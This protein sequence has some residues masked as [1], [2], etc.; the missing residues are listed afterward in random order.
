MNWKSGAMNQGHLSEYFDGA[1]VKILSPVDAEPKSSNQHEIGTTVPMRKFLGTDKSEFDVTYIWLNDEQETITDHGFAT[2]YNCR[3]GKPRPPEYRLYYT[4][5]AVTDIMSAGDTLFLAIRPDETILFIVVPS[6]STIQSQLL[7]LFGLDDEPQKKFKFAEFS[8]DDSKVDFISRFILDEIGIEFEDPDANSLDT[9]I[10]RFGLEFPKTAELSELARLTLPEVNALDDPDFALTAWLD[11]EEALFRRLEKKVVAERIQEGFVNED[12]V[13]VDGFIKYSLSVQ[14]RRKSRMGHSFENQ[15]KAVFDAFKLRYD[16]Q[17]I[18]EKGKK[19]DFIF[20]GKDEYF[21]PEFNTSR[22][23]MLAAKSTCKDRWPQILPEA[24]RIE[25]KHL[26]TLEPAI[27]LPQTSLMQE[28][29]VQ[30]IVPDSIR[31]SYSNLQQENIW[32]IAKFIDVIL[33]RQ[34]YSSNEN[35]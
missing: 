30:L 15:L 2:H 18:T 5:N 3:E 19:P 10:D 9:I 11:H 25:T 12:D 7:W 13:D 29:G 20:P 23:T 4:S 14:N 17:V 22:L 1:G 8:G 6:D 24:E 32:T 26:I 28:S 27:S 16:S 33:H 35:I 31:G 34:K 21:D